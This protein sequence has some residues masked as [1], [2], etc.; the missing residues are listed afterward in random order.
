MQ[1]QG[2]SIKPGQSSSI[3]AIFNSGTYKGRVTKAIYV[4]TNDPKNSEV[5][6]MLNAEVEQLASA[7]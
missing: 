4:Y 6:L 3:K 1:T 7:K 5:V 2:S